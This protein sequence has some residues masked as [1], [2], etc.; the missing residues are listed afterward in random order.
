[1]H[2]SFEWLLDG[3]SRKKAG[4]RRGREREVRWAPANQTGP[5]LQ[6]LLPLRQEKPLQG[7]YGRRPKKLW[8]LSRGTA[9]SGP[10]RG[11]FQHCPAPC[12]V[13]GMRSCW[14]TSPTP[15]RRRVYFYFRFD[16][17]LLTGFCPSLCSASPYLLPSPVQFSLNSHG[18]C[19]PDHGALWNPST[20]SGPQAQED[21]DFQRGHLD[22][23]MAALG[24]A[25]VYRSTQY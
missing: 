7:M 13:R 4:P 14:W 8:A 18:R 5:S 2:L 20:S 19:E 22:R 23:R 6:R 15:C 25:C 9:L 3:A 16:D 1:M 10:L 11:T 17:A 21:G 24:F 12:E